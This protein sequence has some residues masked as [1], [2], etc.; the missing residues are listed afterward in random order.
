M[1]NIKMMDDRHMREIKKRSRKKLE[2][3]KCRRNGK[4]Q[5]REKKQN[6]AYRL[7]SRRRIC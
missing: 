6:G 7:P 5:D 3:R 2:I 1:D 4:V